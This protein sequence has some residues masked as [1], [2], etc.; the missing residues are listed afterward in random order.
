[1][2]PHNGIAHSEEEKLL[3]RPATRMLGQA[4]T[5][6]KSQMQGVSRSTPRQQPPGTHGPGGQGSVPVEGAVPATNRA[7][8]FDADVLSV[9]VKAYVKTH[10]CLCEYSLITCCIM[11]KVYGC[12]HELEEDY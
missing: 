5:A 4:N 2:L 10:L 3:L 9:S 7:E 12:I 6:Q 1:M 8:F 11:G